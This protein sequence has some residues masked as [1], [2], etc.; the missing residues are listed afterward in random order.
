MRW[1]RDK[2][3]TVPHLL[4]RRVAGPEVIYNQK[5][6]S[7]VTGNKMYSLWAFVRDKDEK[8]KPKATWSCW[9]DVGFQCDNVPLR[10]QT[11]TWWLMIA[12]LDWPMKNGVPVLFTHC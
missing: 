12:V 6:T 10:A 3:A 5:T 11:V 4:Q 1:D 8:T 9:T 7:W 2:F